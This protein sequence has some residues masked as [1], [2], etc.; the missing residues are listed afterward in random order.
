MGIMH[1]VARDRNS[2]SRE[3]QR[4]NFL[5]VRWMGGEPGFRGGFKRRR[6]E[7][8]GFVADDGGLGPFGF[9]DPND[10]IRA[11]HILPAFE[12]G[13]RIA[14]PILAPSFCQEAGGD[15]NFFYIMR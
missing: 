15:W 14:D 12:H 4:V 10:I 3:W 13:R 7:R 9:V 8:V 6:L 11:A 5:W 1:I 2:P